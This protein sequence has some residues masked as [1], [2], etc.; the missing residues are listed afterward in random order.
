MAEVTRKNPQ[1]ALENLI[2]R[3]NRKVQQSGM[4]AIA[5]RKQYMEKSPSKRILRE[6]AIRKNQR[7]LERNRRMYMGR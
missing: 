1:E 7:K 2:R 6:S 3:F 4:I 5:R